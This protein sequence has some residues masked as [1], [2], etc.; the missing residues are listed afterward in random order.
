MWFPS[1]SLAT[2]S[3]FKPLLL[4]QDKKGEATPCPPLGVSKEN[5]WQV[6]SETPVFK[7]TV[8]TISPIL[9]W[10]SHIFRLEGR[11]GINLVALA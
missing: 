10:P 2:C 3:S 4:D 7:E 11:D 9:P 6:S 1:S 5:P 8:S